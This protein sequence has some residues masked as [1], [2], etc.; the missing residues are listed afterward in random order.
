MPRPVDKVLLLALRD[1]ALKA[2]AVHQQLPTIGIDDLV[3][4][5]TYAEGKPRHAAR[6]LAALHKRRS[7]SVLWRSPA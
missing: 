3:A 4:A 6:I 7:H 2:N 5:I 1:I